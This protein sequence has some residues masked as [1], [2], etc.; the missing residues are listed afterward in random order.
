MSAAPRI[1]VKPALLG[2]LLIVSC[3]YSTVLAQST[4]NNNT[5]TSTS[6]G[7]D[8]IWF[9]DVQLWNITNNTSAPV[10]APFR[11]SPTRR[12]PVQKPRT[13]NVNTVSSTTSTTSSPT[14]MAPTTMAPSTPK[15]STPKPSSAKP[16]TSTPTREPTPAPTTRAPTL[17]PTT[18]S[19]SVVPT[20]TPTTAAPTSQGTIPK[21]RMTLKYMPTSMDTFTEPTWENITS[22][23]VMN[24]WQTNSGKHN[25]TVQGLHVTTLLVDQQLT[26]ATRRRRRQ[27]QT[28]QENSIVYQ[29][30]V[31]YTQLESSSSTTNLDLAT[32]QSLV[33]TLPFETLTS[34][35]QYVVQLQAT[36]N[37]AFQNVFTVTPVSTTDPTTSTNFFQQN[38][39]WIAI[40]AAAVAVLLF[41]IFFCYFW[42]CR[43][44]NHKHD[45]TN[46]KNRDDYFS[47]T[48]YYTNGGTASQSP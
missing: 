46:T 11:R 39:M 20:V 31:S 4:N 23:F 32:M 26:P 40:G 24:Y 3:C 15:P 17:A 13:N 47:G 43:K 37:S 18:N 14:T 22:T 27:L 8:L 28:Q 36:G 5:N 25:L 29:Q 35:T 42:K 9:N 33:A 10:R 34:R 41:L 12:R 44:E 7:D 19:P 45:L 21:L 30:I 38:W 1:V 2:L 16:T 48:N 6:N